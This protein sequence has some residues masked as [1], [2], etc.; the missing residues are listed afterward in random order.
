M[1]NT[2]KAVKI[3]DHVYW[4]GAIDW[5]IRDF[6]GYFTKR[7]TTYN[8]FLIMADK[9][10]LIDTVK[11]PFL[12]EMM[13]RIASVTDPA[14]IDYIVSNHAEMD[15]S[16]CLPSLLHRIKPEKVFASTH[17]VKCLKEHFHFDHEL[18]EVKNG[19]KLSLGD[20][21]LSF[22]ATP[23]LHW[24]D[25]MFSLLE[26][27]GVLFSQDA[28][29]M[30]LASNVLFADEQREWVLRYEAAKYFANILLPY[31]SRVS[32]L[33]EKTAGL[34][35]GIRIVAPDHGPIWRQNVGF[36][37]DCYHEW[38]AQKP[39]N[40]A[41]VIY[42]TMWESTA[43]MAEAI[44]EG[45]SRRGDVW[46]KVLPI[47]TSHRSDIATEVF[48]AGALIV[49]SPTLNNNLFPTVADL[50][51]YLKGLKPLNK[52]GAAF[53]SY[54]WSGESIKQIN[55]FLDEMNVERIGDGIK[56]RY[57]PDNSVLE[58]CVALGRSVADRMMEKVPSKDEK[59]RR[60]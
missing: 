29:G 8:A 51:Y 17:G 16:G 21:T 25:S 39:T 36:I 26:E 48:D 44:G 41:V 59:V 20:M 46:V 23:M 55:A 18:T 3:T 37:I 33:M 1:T 14:N 13:S 60:V 11:K 6:H 34:I 19:E 56:T 49:G 40:K 52:V 12:D 24:P 30:H 28:F 42:D 54:G 5:A 4:V 22:L 45:L 50:L 57:V 2:F 9:I 35:S 58:E 38:S 53:G 10:T 15:H 43:R 7:G 31:A 47:R 27:E 32:D